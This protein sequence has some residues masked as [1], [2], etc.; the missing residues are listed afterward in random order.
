MSSTAQVRGDQLGA[1][2][3]RLRRRNARSAAMSPI[4]LPRPGLIPSMAS[5]RGAVRRE[6]A[7]LADAVDTDSD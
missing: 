6:R 2:W 4:T 3:P 5:Y 7:D 1:M